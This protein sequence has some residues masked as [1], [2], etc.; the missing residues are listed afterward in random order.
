MIRFETVASVVRHSDGALSSSSS[1]V[2]AHYTRCLAMAMAMALLLAIPSL[3][4]Q[5][6]E[7]QAPPPT[8][9][10]QRVWIEPAAPGPET[11]CQ[12]YVELE[13]HGERAASLFAFEVEVGGRSL[14][15]YAKE[16]FAFPVAPGKKE[17]VRL[18]N[19]W[20]SET[21]RPAPADGKL[22]VAV[23]LV[24]ARWIEIEVEGDEETWTP[25]GEVAGLPSESELVVSLKKGS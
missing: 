23:R 5:A 20:T 2:V 21:G 6:E 11:L 1:W 19:F 14:P 24:E 10:I 13:S 17:T 8:V 22:K 15:V 9:S 3:W 12:L 7:G 16:L 25:L 18:F 4:A